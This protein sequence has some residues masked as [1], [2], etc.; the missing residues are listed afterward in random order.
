MLPRRSA[1]QTGE[2]RKLARPDLAE[3]VKFCLAA[4]VLRLSGEFRL[5]AMGASMLPAIWPGDI[6]TVRAADAG[7]VKPGEIVLCSRDDRFVIHRVVENRGGRLITRGDALPN[8]DPPVGAGDLLGRV[9]SIERAS[10]RIAVRPGL[11]LSGRL[12]SLL[13]SHSAFVTRLALRFRRN[14]S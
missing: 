3:T 2:T 8:N 13:L 1:G 5:R 9:V 11:S 10:S 6:L 4:E 7:G 14:P 12:L